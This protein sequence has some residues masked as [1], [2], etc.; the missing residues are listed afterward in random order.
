[1]EL[2]YTL[3]LPLSFIG[4]IFIVVSIVAKI[5]RKNFENKIRNDKNE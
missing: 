3:V 2:I 5:S 4:L 1:M